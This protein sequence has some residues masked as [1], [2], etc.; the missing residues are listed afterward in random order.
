M[1]RIVADHEY[2]SV[3]APVRQVDDNSPPDKISWRAALV[4]TA[5]WST[6]VLTSFVSIIL[7]VGSFSG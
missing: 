3:P 5:L 4:I 6:V 7:I 1:F 2:S